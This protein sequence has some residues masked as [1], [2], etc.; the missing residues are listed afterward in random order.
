[1]CMDI[2]MVLTKVFR[3]S[4][5]K[6]T[7]NIKQDIQH[8]ET[9]EHTRTKQRN[10]A[11]CFY[12]VVVVLCLFFLFRLSFVCDCVCLCLF[13]VV[14]CWCFCVYILFFP[15][16]RGFKGVII[17]VHGPNDGANQGISG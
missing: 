1:M 3:H 10:R 12:V 13:V 15:I 4:H 16:R 17:D 9:T 14:F 5:R 6:H 7:T 11:C 2:V 8:P